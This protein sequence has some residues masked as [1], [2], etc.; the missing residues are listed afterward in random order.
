MEFSRQDLY[1]ESPWM[2]A[3]GSLGFTPQ[4]R[5]PWPEK[6]G[7]FVTNPVSRSARLPAEETHVLPTPGGFLLHTGWPNPGYR[8]CL[9]RY[10]DYWAGSSLPVWVHLL[11]ETPEDTG[12]MAQQLE[13]REGVLAV[14][15]GLPPAAADGEKLAFVQAARGELPLVVCVSLTEIHSAWVDRL[16]AA[17]ASAV[18][19]TA[20]RGS[21]PM[22]GGRTAAGRLYGAALFPLVLDAVRRLRGFRLPVIAGCGVFDR[23]SGQACLQAG[24]WA[25]QVDAALWQVRPPFEEPARA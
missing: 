8:Q 19:I 11:A 16:P 24:A 5:W 12:W 25:V 18:V 10:A 1:V 14:E 13:G 4:P 7:A 17:G 20:P 6:Q 9:R 23:E 15:L 3:A 2:N 22:P 21:L